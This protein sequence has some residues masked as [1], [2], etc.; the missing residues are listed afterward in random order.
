[1]PNVL[2]APLHRALLPLAHAI[3]HAWR[4]WRKAPI[5]G[6]SVIVTNLGGDVL[7]LKHSYG[8]AVWALPGGGLGKGEDPLEAAR[9]EVREELGVELVRLEPVGTI[10]EVLSGSPHTAHI[11]TGVCDRHP[12]PDRREVTEARF[13]PSHSLPEPLGDTTRARI[14]MWKAR[15]VGQG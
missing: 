2:P 7:L 11:F 10:E 5:A 12:E 6:V 4:R 9:R 1:M 3:R 14:A 15:G 13:F 8:P